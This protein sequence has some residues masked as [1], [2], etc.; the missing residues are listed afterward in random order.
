MFCIFVSYLLWLCPL[1][2][3]IYSETS[4]KIIRERKHNFLPNFAY[5]KLAKQC[6]ARFNFSRFHDEQRAHLY[7]R[8]KERVLMYLCKIDS[9][10]THTSDYDCHQLLAEFLNFKISD[11]TEEGHF[12]LFFY[13]LGGYLEM[14]YV[15]E[16]SLT[17]RQFYV[18]DFKRDIVAL[19]AQPVSLPEM[20]LTRDE[21]EIVFDQ[22]Y[23]AVEKQC[24][25]L[26]YIKNFLNALLIEI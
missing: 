22:H 17:I 5:Q 6:I 10:F 26:L 21:W 25:H 20:P 11:E 13:L 3:G 1:N 19:L 16:V 15:T 9:F 23:S 8:I 4:E 18:L 12:P 14:G 2:A 24:A 7:S